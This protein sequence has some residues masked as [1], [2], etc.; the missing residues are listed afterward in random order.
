MKLFA[1]YLTQEESL[2]INR[3][4]K[5]GWLTLGQESE[6]FAAKIAA[7][8]GSRYAVAVNN[9]T[10][11]L[12][13]AVIASGLKLGDE[14]ITTPYTFVASTNCLLFEKVK[15]VFADISS[16]TLNLNPEEIAAKITSK[17]KAILAVDVFGYPADWNKII[18][19]AKKFNLQIIEDGAEAFGAIYHKRK[20]GNLGHLTTFSF[21]PNKQI[22]TGEGGAVTTNNFYQ[23][24]YISSLTNQGRISNQ[25]PANHQYLGY[26]YRLAELPAAIGNAQFKKINF[27]LNNRKLIAQWYR[28]RLKNI[29]GIRLPIEDDNVHRRS[30]FVYTVILDK[31]FNRETIAAKLIKSGIPIKTYFPAIHLQPYLKYLGYQ[32]G[33]FPITESVADSALSLPFYTGM[34][35]SQ[36]ELVCKYLKR[37]INT[38]AA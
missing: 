38:C 32:R 19:L 3:V 36:V 25:S 11:A 15:P 16:T 8:T 24:K 2:A 34:P 31:K 1:P 22:T 17:T 7:F 23:Y 13:L 14:V 27:I 10:A 28:Q 29:S 35:E 9:G 6:K 20:V 21:F 37:A 33:D 18:A 5:K 4:L 12:H 26:N 30:W